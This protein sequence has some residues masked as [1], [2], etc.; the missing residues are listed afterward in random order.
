MNTRTSRTVVYLVS[1]FIVGLLADRMVADR[2]IT[3]VADV[4]AAQE[5][6]DPSHHTCSDRTLRGTYGLKLEGR[7]L[8]AGPF[9]SVSQLRFDGN[10]HMTGSEIGSL[11]GQIVQRTVAG[12]Y[13][14]NA[15]CTGF[16]II[17][18]TLVRPHDARGDFVLVDGGREFF[19]IDNEE[20]WVLNG[21]GKKF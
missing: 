2:K 13:T 17:P 11:N 8:A 21:V 18:S 20:G 15:D 9:A 5:N 16:I 3:L 4:Q 10:G 6:E 7:S 19:M 14:V 12:S 1:A